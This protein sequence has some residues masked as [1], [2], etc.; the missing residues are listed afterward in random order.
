MGSDGIRLDQITGTGTGEAL[1]GFMHCQTSAFVHLVLLE[2]NTSQLILQL[3]ALRY[4]Q[5]QI[6]R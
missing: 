4:L 2:L 1:T 5:Q 6:V 3:A